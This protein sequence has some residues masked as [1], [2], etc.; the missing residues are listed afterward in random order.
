MLPGIDGGRQYLYNKVRKI[1][2]RCRI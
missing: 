2:K 1:S